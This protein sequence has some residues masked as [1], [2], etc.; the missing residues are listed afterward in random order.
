MEN[1]LTENENVRLMIS[2]DTMEAIKHLANHLDLT[3][4]EVVSELVFSS[5]GAEGLSPSQSKSAPG[6]QPLPANP[7]KDP[8]PPKHRDTV[9]QDVSC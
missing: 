3:S 2:Q 6:T 8:C 7:G 5:L 4:S 9:C 1:N